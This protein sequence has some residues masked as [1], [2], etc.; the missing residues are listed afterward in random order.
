MTKPIQISLE[1]WKEIAALPVVKESWGIEDGETPENVASMI[2]GVKFLFVSG[3]P[4][5]VG[6]L[7][8]LHGDALGEP[9]FVLFRR[10]GT[11][12]LLE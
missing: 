7:Y 6:D 2:Y 10:D 12:E 8:I 3:G 11:L 5:Y 1:E 4:G 9:P